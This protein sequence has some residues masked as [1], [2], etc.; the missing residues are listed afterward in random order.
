MKKKDKSR[1][2]ILKG[3][4]LHLKG[5]PLKKIDNFYNLYFHENS[6]REVDISFTNYL[7]NNTIRNRGIIE[8]ILKQYVKKKNYLKTL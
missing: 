1:I 2:L 4:T 5:M 6:F 3:L 8:A 7:T